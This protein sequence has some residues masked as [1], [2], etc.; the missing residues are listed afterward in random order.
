VSG[1]Y[2]HRPVML[3]EVLA[4]LTPRSGGKYF[5]GTLGGAG[6]ARAILEASAP[7]GFLYGCDLDP[8][9]IEEAK[10]RLADFEGRWE[11]RQGNY[12]QMDKWVPEGS[13][14]GVLLDLGVSSYLLEDAERGFS[15]G[16]DGPLD[17]RM[18]P[19]SG[20]T[21]ADVVNN[22]TQE[23]LEEI[24]RNLGDVEDAGKIAREIVNAR[25]VG[26][27]VSTL[28]LAKLVERVAGRCKKDIHP[29]TQVFMA[30]RIYV[31]DEYGAIKRGLEAALKILKPGGRLAVIT[32]HSGE[33][34]IVKNFGREKS[35]NYEVI[36]EVDLPEFRKPC[37]PKLKIVYRKPVV[38]DAGEIR[39]NPRARSAKLRVFEK[40]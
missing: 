17:M 38:P 15:F 16:R 35:R 20:L 29:A 6:H 24:F 13:C 40:I 1:V 32:F 30:L 39:E 9:A 5:D 10:R 7:D 23:E 18:N 2:I 37:E 19:D 14:D 28:Q 21:A 22:F 11:I 8:R 34:R 27:I 33:D 31:N 12:D 4:A 3:K 25:R 36:G 26:G